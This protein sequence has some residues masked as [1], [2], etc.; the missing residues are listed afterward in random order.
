MRKNKA[1]R[2]RKIENIKK[3]V[4]DLRNLDLSFYEIGKELGISRQLAWYHYRDVDNSTF[5]K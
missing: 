2:P 5:V 3:L 1:G 4:A